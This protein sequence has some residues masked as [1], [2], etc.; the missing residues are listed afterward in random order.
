MNP[1]KRNF[2]QHALAVGAWMRVHEATGGMDIVSMQMQ[3]SL[4]DKSL[5]FFPQFTADNQDG[6][7][8]FVN[9]MING[10]NGF[11]GWYPY[12]SKV[13]PAAQNKLTFKQLA[14]QYKLRTPP[15]TQ[16]LGQVTGAF[17]VKAEQSSLG[18]GLRGPFHVQAGAA[19]PEGVR[20]DTGEYAEQFILGRLVKA[21]YWNNQL[22]VAELS[23]MPYVQGDGSSTIEQLLRRKL[24]SDQSLPEPLD[25][26]L[27]L[28]N[29]QRFS[30]LPKGQDAAVDYRYMSPLNPAITQDHNVQP[31]IKG[32]QLEAQLL[33]AGQ[34]FWDDMP[35]SQREGS[36]SSADGIMDEQGRVWFLEL[37]CNP[38]LHPAFYAT[39]L[40]GLFG[41][42][43]DPKTNAQVTP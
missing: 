8:G 31:H 43:T 26:L 15:W 29:L 19:R 1:F 37:N 25:N 5:R 18:H 9:Q 7:L 27:S 10:V 4:G 3:I 36:I 16:D 21:W 17:I 2:L 42:K 38:L 39:M 12:Q 22:A 13:W 11:V 23:P 41:V 35:A 6:T 30:V 40:D 28:Q 33:H 20:L 32:S 24:A 14:V 34:C